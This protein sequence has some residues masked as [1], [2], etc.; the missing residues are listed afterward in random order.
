[1]TLA[2]ALIVLHERYD[3]VSSDAAS[4]LYALGSLFVA[5]GLVLRLSFWVDR[6]DRARA[7]AI[8]ELVA[9]EARARELIEHAPEAI[10]VLDV[11]RGRFVRVNPEAEHLLGLPTHELLRR[12][13][14]DVSVPMQADGR[15][16]DVALQEQL[17]PRARR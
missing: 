2:A 1:M 14:L 5:V 17:D 10:V 6:V 4:A 7:V 12:G 9:S 13:P 3:L 8:Q 15:P 16:S 11:D